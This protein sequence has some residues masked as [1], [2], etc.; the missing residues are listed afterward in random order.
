MSNEV[1]YEKIT[2]DRMKQPAKELQKKSFVEALG[3]RTQSV[4]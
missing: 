4:L 3:P 2:E 1:Y